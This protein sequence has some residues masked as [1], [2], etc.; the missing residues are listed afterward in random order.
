MSTPEKSGA[1]MPNQKEEACAT[2]DSVRTT[3]AGP[4]DTSSGAKGSHDSHGPTSR[5]RTIVVDPPWP[6]AWKPAS[7][8]RAGGKWSR[9]ERGERRSRKLELAYP[10]MTL[11][12]IRRLPVGD[13]AQEDAVV[14]I[15][16][17]RRLFRDGETATVARAWGFEPCG[18]I[19]WGLRNPGLGS[20]AHAN[21]HEPILIARR[22]ALTLASEVPLGVYFWRQL[23][24][25]DGRAP[26]KI[27][28]AKPE[29]FLDLVESTSPGPY[30][31]LFARRQRLGWDTWGN[32]AL[33]HVEMSA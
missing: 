1:N 12:Q 9:K 5:Y 24:G 33:E 31:E 20:G 15:W 3:S 17:T 10:V 8:L 22:G 19:I 16:S 11:D 29:A 6:I 2:A 26:Y 14:F 25:F 28:S 30:L 18:E 27:H 23:Y 13:L 7:D 21:D 4:A 32:E